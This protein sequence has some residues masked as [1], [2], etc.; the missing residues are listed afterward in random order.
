MLG[1]TVGRYIIT[2]LRQQQQNESSE[3]THRS[4]VDVEIKWIINIMQNEFGSVAI[5][6][7]S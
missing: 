4:R 7:E 3:R 6:Q 5:E 2:D 1:Y